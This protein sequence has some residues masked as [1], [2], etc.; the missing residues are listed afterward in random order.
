MHLM[1]ANFDTWYELYSIPASPCA[2][3]V[4]CGHDM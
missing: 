1:R 4:V 2:Q 3:K